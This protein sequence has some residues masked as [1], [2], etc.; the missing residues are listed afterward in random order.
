MKRIV[1]PL[2]AEFGMKV[3]WHAPAVHAIAGDKIVCIEP[4]DEALYPSATEFRVVTQQHDDARRNRYSRDREFLDNVQRD[5]ITEYGIEN[6]EL[7]FPHDDWPRERF[8]PEPRVRQGSPHLYPD[9]VVCPRRRRYGAEK[10]WPEWH[11]LTAGLVADGFTVFAAG[12]PD[13]SYEVPCPQAWDYDRFLDASI[14]AMLNAKLVVTTDAGLAHL[15]VLCGR[16]TAVI[17]H[18]DLLVA[19]GP[20]I[21]ETGRQMEDHYWPVKLERYVEGNHTDAPL[22]FLDHAWYDPA[23]VRRTI[24]R[25]MG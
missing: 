10:N 20:V 16:P 1:M 24:R 17:T 12:A 8:I 25:L 7:I 2:R 4:G 23:N 18:G 15:A 3:W 6:V 11:D 14:E 13:S 9:I 19:P 5:V 22:F 21:D